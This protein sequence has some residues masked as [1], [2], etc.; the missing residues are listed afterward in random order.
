MTTLRYKCLFILSIFLVLAMVPAACAGDETESSGPDLEVSIIHQWVSGGE[1]ES[2]RAVLSPWEEENNGQV[3]DQGTRDLLEILEIRI[4]GDNPPDMAALAAPGTMVEFARAGKLVPLNDILDMDKIR[5]EYSQTWLDMGTVDGKLYALPY[6]TANKATV[7]YNPRLFQ[8]NSLEVPGTWEELVALSDY[9]ADTVGLKPW[10]LGMESGGSSG[11]PG[12]DWIGQILLSESGPEVYDQWVNH[13]IPWTDAQI[14]SAWEKFGQIALTTDYVYGGTDFIL[15]TKFDTASYLPFESPPRAAMYF[16][17]SF[18]QGFI[19]GQ[20][21][22]LIP[23]EDYDFFPFP[24]INADYQNAATSGADLLVMFNQ[25]EA[26]VSLME[27]LISAEAQEIAVSQGGF[28]SSNHHVKPGAYQN[29]LAARVSDELANVSIARFDADD[30]W[31]GELQAA[32]WQGV[33]DYLAE[34]SGLDS[35]LANIEAVAVE[36]LD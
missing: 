12:T 6:K 21:P 27:H 4:A 11:W 34:P 5:E 36:Q 31:G 16:L 15:T 35:I 20:L 19:E 29:E 26:S 14:R 33:L 7:W 25:T 2:F 18:V 22:E 23:G 32:F 30:I 10:S 9:L 8:A 13:D 28:I 1:P 17:G 24:T 3:K